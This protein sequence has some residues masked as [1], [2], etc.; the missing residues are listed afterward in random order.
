M[1]S[2]N[3]INNETEESILLKSKRD[4]F[5]NEIRKKKNE[6]ILNSKRMKFSA[7]ETGEGG[8]LLKEI[9]WVP[10]ILILINLT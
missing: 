1:I 4:Q 2:T 3:T 7:K 5:A 6:N 10:I 9:E 8:G